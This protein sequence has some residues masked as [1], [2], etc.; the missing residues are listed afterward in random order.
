M[1]SK[2]SNVSSIPEL[3]DFEV[4]YSLLTNEVYLSTSFT[5]NMA[6]IPNWPLQELPDQFMCISRT[7]AVALIEELQKAI[8]Y[9]NAGIERRSENLIQ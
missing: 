9:M 8:D 5:D 1:T 6:C 7:R 2:D 3:T 4:S